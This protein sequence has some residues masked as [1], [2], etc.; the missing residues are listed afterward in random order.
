[1]SKNQRRPSVGAFLNP[2]YRPE[3]YGRRLNDHIIACNRCKHK[4]R[5]AWKQGTVCPVCG[6]DHFYPVVHFGSKIKK[7]NIT[8]GLF[9]FLFIIFSMLNVHKKI[10]PIEAAFQIKLVCTE[11][12]KIVQEWVT[13]DQKYPAKC[14]EGHWGQKTLYPAYQCNQG[15]VFG[16]DIYENPENIDDDRNN[17]ESRLSRICPTCRSTAIS[18]VPVDMQIDQ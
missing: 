15:H 12:G 3:K 4:A 10:A 17:H 6:S 7:R 13:V 16:D 14:P 8:I 1:M 18:R 9:V 11:H 2:F 5:M